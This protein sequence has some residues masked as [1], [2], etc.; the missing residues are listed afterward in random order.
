M[1]QSFGGLRI[2]AWGLGV[3]RVE[4]RH[5]YESCLGCRHTQ[6]MYQEIKPVC[7]GFHL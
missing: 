2:R 5:G 7:K 1:V 3:F 6:R 4:G